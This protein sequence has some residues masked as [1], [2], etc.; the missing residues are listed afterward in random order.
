MSKKIVYGFFVLFFITACGSSKDIDQKPQIS[1]ADYPYIETFHKGVRLKA[2]GRVD[3]AI[4]EFKKCLVIRQDDDAVYFALSQLELKR[5]NEPEASNYILQAAELDPK[6]IWYTQELAYMYF[7][8]QDFPKAV[9]QFEKLVANEPRNIEWQYGYAESLLK[10]G[11]VPGAIGALD[12]TQD[13]V[14]LNPQLSIQKYELYME[15]EKPEEALNEIVVARE[16]YASDAQLIATLVDHYF[17]AGEN[18]KAV[19]MLEA[20]VIADPEN[21]RAHLALADVYRREGKKAKSYVA[22]NKAFKASDVTVDNK[23][24]ILMT[25]NESSTAIDP[26]VYELVDIMVEQYPTSAKAHS[27]HGDF[28]L[29]ANKNDEALAAYKKALK[30]DENQFPIWKQVLIMQYQSGA[31]ESLYMDSKAC[32]EL[33]PTST[34]VYILNGLA[35]NQTKRHEEAIDALSV[36]YE[37]IIND[38]PMQ[39]EFCG[40][41]GDAYFGLKDY[42]EAKRYYEKGLKLDPRSLLL[43]KNFALG[44]ARANIDLEIAESMIIEATDAASGQVDFIDTYGFVLFQKGDYAAAKLKFEEAYELDDLNESILE[45]LGDVAFKLGSVEN[46]VEWW[47]KAKSIRSNDLLEKKI[48]DKKYYGP[49]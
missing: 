5:D 30:Y 43:R 35:A 20:L 12:K 27:I 31:N 49:E 21:G 3:E 1:T 19:E 24:R 28:L 39:A 37:L 23:M 44:L 32:L 11:D 22:L 47:N 16:T 40:Q 4:A 9:S 10:S 46:A 14:G 15:I 36:G 41:L 17:D 42:S 2:K 48:N 45:H 18:D 13:Q 6:N 7:K 38:V 33:F 8:R 29:G 26:E 34:T 25:I